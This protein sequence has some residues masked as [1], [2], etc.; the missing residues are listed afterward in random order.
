MARPAVRPIFQKR[1]LFVLDTPEHC[2][3]HQTACSSPAPRGILTP[4]VFSAT[5]PI[6]CDGSRQQNRFQRCFVRCLTGVSGPLL[7]MAVPGSHSAGYWQPAVF[8]L[9]CREEMQNQRPTISFFRWCVSLFSPP[10]D[11]RSRSCYLLWL[12]P[13]QR[14]CALMAGVCIFKVR[15]RKEPLTL[16][17]VG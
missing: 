6:A 13:K 2:G 17:A 8:S 1:S 11:P 12:S 14:E 3:S 7:V 10:A 16:F 9:R 4:R 15:L 5:A